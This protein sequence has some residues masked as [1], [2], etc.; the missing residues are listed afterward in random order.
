MT[1]AHRFLVFVLAALGGASVN[2]DAAG[3]SEG[4]KETDANSGATGAGHVNFADPEQLLARRQRREQPCDWESYEDGQV[5]RCEAAVDGAVQLVVKATGRIYDWLKKSDPAARKALD[6]STAAWWKYFKQCD[7]FAP[8]PDVLKAN[9]QLAHHGAAGM[10]RYGILADRL[11][12][13]LE[14]EE[15][16]KSHRQGRSAKK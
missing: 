16:V 5:L 3:T 8:D 2:A 9:G 1:H 7:L 12:E 10:C 4:K 14:F 15:L 6:A 11:R 13:L